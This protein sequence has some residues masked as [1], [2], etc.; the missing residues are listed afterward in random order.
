M[1]N[2]T[3]SVSNPINILIIENDKASRLNLITLLKRDNYN[4]FEA[5]DRDEALEIINDDTQ[6]L[7]II[8]LNREM[9]LNSGIELLKILKQDLKITVTTSACQPT[10]CYCLI[11][12]QKTTLCFMELL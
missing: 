8:F 1:Q 9:P 6:F 10:N 5:E 3:S 11:Q 12:K 4:I 7:D 2:D